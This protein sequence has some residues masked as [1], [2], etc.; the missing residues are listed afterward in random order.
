MAAEWFT[1]VGGVITGPHTPAALKALAACGALPPDGRVR[2]GPA[3]AWVRADGVTGLTFPD[4]PD[5]PDR[6]D[7]NDDDD[8]SDDE[9][10]ADTSPFPRQR[11][12]MLRTIATLARVFAGL[13]GL[14]A[15]VAAVYGL[16]LAATG[17]RI[18][19]FFAV[20]TMTGAGVWGVVTVIGFL[21]LA[22]GI[23]LA[24][25]VEHTLREIRD[26]GRGGR[27]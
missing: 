13:C 2:R 5:A 25:D 22:E 23:S 11:Y 24:I 16:Y 19:I 17:N 27:G 14:V 12:P 26:Q 18:D 9:E 1:R 15:V 8:E 10:P 7:D 20:S 3:G 4:P 21:V 6:P